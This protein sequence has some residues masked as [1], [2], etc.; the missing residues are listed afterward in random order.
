MKKLIFALMVS[1]AVT[2]SADEPVVDK[3]KIPAAASRDVDFV[4]DIQ[5]LLEA[6][7]VKCH[8]GK[9]AKH[10]YWMDEKEKA[11]AGGKSEVAAIVPGKSLESTVVQFAA[12]AV[13]DDDYKMPPLDKREKYKVW[14]KDQIGLVRAWIDQG[15]KWPDGL[16]LKAPATE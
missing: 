8:S 12:D 14:T 11:F 1:T 6:S 2:A 7:C 5:P 15:A 13:E 3:S 16:I 9:R 4:K 10:K